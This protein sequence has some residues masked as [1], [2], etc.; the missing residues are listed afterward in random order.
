MGFLVNIPLY[1]CK[2]ENQ[3]IEGRFIGI[4]I[5]VKKNFCSVVCIRKL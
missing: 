3:N 1:I 2:P 4:Y 5:E